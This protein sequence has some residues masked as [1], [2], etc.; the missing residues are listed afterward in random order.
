MVVPW[1]NV[2]TIWCQVSVSSVPHTLW[3]F[4]PHYDHS[5]LPSVFADIHRLP[6]GSVF[7]VSIDM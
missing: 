4:P 1:S 3:Y 2:N 6:P 5:P 7:F